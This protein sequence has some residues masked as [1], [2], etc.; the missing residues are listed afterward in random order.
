M[1][2]PDPGLAP[3]RGYSPG[4]YSLPPPGA[5]E[6]AA[7]E[8]DQL[9]T[10]DHRIVLDAI[11]E[12]LAYQPTVR[13]RRRKELTNLTPSFEHVAPVWQLK[14]DDFRVFYAVDEH[15]HEVHVRAVR[16]KEP[17]A[18]TEDIT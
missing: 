16:R 13:T 14:V 5:Q 15:A 17:E 12:H 6:L 2:A 11:E 3:L 18:R 10:Y 8:L 9:R 4:L 1:E 7:D